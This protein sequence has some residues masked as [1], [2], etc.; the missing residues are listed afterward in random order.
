MRLELKSDF[1]VTDAACRK[2]TGK[3]MK[4]WFDEIGARPAVQRGVEV[5]A[6]Q[7]KPLVDDKAREALFGDRQYTRR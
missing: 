1:P 5:L 3:T 4:A 7:R 6:D 2:E